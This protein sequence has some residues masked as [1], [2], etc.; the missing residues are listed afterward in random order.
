MGAS[1]RP[2][3]GAGDLVESR[4]DGRGWVQ[5]SSSMVG[6]GERKADGAH[7]RLMP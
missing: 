5:V 6:V 4:V 2:I 3:A 1:T 7:E